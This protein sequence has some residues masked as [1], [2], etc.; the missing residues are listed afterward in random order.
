MQIDKIILH[1]F[2]V[3][4]GYQEVDLTPDS[5]RKP[6]VLFGG[7]NGAGKTTLLDAI[8]LCLFGP[9]AKCSSRNG[10]GYTEYLAGCIN[11]S[12]A[13][14]EALIGLDFRHTSNGEETAYSIRRSWSQRGKGLSELFEVFIDGHLT[15]ALTKSWLSHIEE[16]IPANI[17][18]LFFFDGEQVED[19]VVAERA[20][21]LI[22][23]AVMNLLG[24]DIIIQLD[25]DLRT[26]SQRKAIKEL[27]ADR[28][29]ETGHLE[30]AT[31]ALRAEAERLNQQAAW[32]RTYELDPRTRKLSELRESFR[33][34]GGDL[35]DRSAEIE[36]RA[37][38]SRDELA[39]C[40]DDLRRLAEGDLP[41]ALVQDLLAS[42]GQRDLRERKTIKAQDTAESIRAI[43]G[44][45]LEHLQQSG[46]D[47]GGMRLVEAF[48]ARRATQD[49]QAQ[50]GKVENPVDDHVRLALRM[51]IDG[52]LKQ[53]AEEAEG[54][55]DRRDGAADVLEDAEL[56]WA[57]VPKAD[58]MKQLL[59]DIKAAEDSLAASRR[60]LTEI[61]I[62]RDLLGK[63]MQ[64]SE[65]RLQALLADAAE[66]EIKDEEKARVLAHSAKAR[67][68]LAEFRHRVIRKHIRHIQSLV[69]ENYQSLLRKEALVA[70]ID[71]DPETFRVWLRDKDNRTVPIERLSAGERQLLAISILWGMG[72]ASG[73]PLPT[74]IDTPLGRLDSTHRDHL[75]RR[76]FPA[77][78]HQV[79]LFSTDQEIHGEHLDAL[80]G[81]VSRSYR[82]EHDDRAGTTKIKEGYLQ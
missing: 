48:L 79:L 75:V 65:S 11:K 56:E 21:E 17:A 70:R 66:R 69:L 62:K 33:K 6:V 25:K 82:L 57:S 76:Y 18:H 7:M 37:K 19:Y 35:Y 61:E 29:A 46:M 31:E 16:I 60:E 41:L 72:K 39:A 50:S 74:A 27:S 5:P 53:A 10:K 81:K 36:A 26:L 44:E 77:A 71:I 73:R 23:T 15:E 45:L 40:E 54:L 80:W 42:L 4:G 12:A 64:Q 28:Q 22:E 55:I 20:G 30:E 78:S 1:D 32:L 14:R 63:Q 2:G 34:A 43:M 67:E 59:D 3:Y 13:R 68:T 24:L 8:Q 49:E 52:R 51:L 9:I 58:D 38:M 47:R